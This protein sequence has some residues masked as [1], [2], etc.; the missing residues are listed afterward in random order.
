MRRVFRS[1]M[2]GGVGG[3]VLPFLRCRK[4]SNAVEFAILAPLLCLIL[5]GTAYVGIYVGTAHSLAQIAA[6]VSRYAMVGTD[7]DNRRHM[8]ERWLTATGGG[9]PLVDPRRMTVAVSE[10]TGLL[11]VRISYDMSYLPMP[12]IVRQSAL[13]PES[14]VRSA[15]VLIP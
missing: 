15:A 6:D 2:V 7:S 12:D 10:D 5:L 8:A 11:R 9:Y 14:L 4:G 1:D 13:M 3:I